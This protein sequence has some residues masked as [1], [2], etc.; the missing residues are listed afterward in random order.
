MTHDEKTPCACDCSYD[1]SRLKDDLESLRADRGQWV[2]ENVQM[3]VVLAF[4][5]GLLRISGHPAAAD[6][7]D[8]YIKKSLAKIEELKDA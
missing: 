3:G 6:I 7:A 5:P 1:C 4:I 2:T 8:G